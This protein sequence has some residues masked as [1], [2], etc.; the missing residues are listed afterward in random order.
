MFNTS[1]Q[2]HS[3]KEIRLTGNHLD[4]TVISNA[5]FAFHLEKLFYSINILQPVWIDLTRQVFRRGGGGV[6]LGILGGGSPN[7]DPISDQKM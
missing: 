5:C 4:V 6:L 7:P 3:V 2:N 1:F